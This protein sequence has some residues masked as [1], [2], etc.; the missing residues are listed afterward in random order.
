MNGASDKGRIDLRIVSDIHY[1]GAG[2]RA[3]GQFDWSS[4]PNPLT[5]LLGRLYY[6]HVWLA[7]PLAHNGLLD[8]FIAES[9]RAD[10]V[11][12]NGDY[13]CD[14][15]FVGVRDDAACESV[16]ECLGKLRQNFSGRFQAIIGDHELGKR[17]L[18]GG[19]GAMPLASWTRTVGELGI[20]P[21]WRVELGNYV[22]LGVASSLVALPVY[23]ADTDEHERA[24]WTRLR[25]EHF[26]A[27]RE[28]FTSLKPQQRVLLFCH[29]PSALPFLWRDEAVRARLAQVEQTIIG[30]LHTRL[31]FWKS[32]ML[33]G[34][35]RIH[36]LGHS[37]RR[38]TSAL[39]EAKCWRQF[40]ARLCPATAGVELLKDGGYLS[41]RLDLEARRPAEFR[42]HPLPR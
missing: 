21:F 18:L 7:D 19:A 14:S 41:A 12:A 8:R 31:V 35:P 32:R 27:I 42:F 15:A 13:T 39:N 17:N 36:F 25:E 11:V 38:M 9:A 1:A 37:A 4:V 10:F 28:A 6:R 30:H 3:R 2:E 16:R 20:Q 29:D 24:E 23:E 40:R 5:R 33:A 26:A 22:L 34:M